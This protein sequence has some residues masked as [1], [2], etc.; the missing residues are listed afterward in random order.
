MPG[1]TGIPGMPG[2]SGFPSFSSLGVNSY[3]ATQGA[4]SPRVE[5]PQPA[6]TSTPLSPG[7]NSR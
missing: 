6:G 1:M 3:G 2:M 7:A 4:T 5:Q